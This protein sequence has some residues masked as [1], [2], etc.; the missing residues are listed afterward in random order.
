MQYVGS[1]SCGIWD[2]VPRQEF[3]PGPPALAA[4]SLGHWITREVLGKV[5]KER[6]IFN[7][8]NSRAWKSRRKQEARE[9]LMGQKWGGG[10][11]G[12]DQRSLAEV[13]PSGP[14]GPCSG[15]FWFS[16]ETQD[17]HLRSRGGEWCLVKGIQGWSLGL[18]LSFWPWESPFAQK[19]NGPGVQPLLQ[20]GCPLPREG[21]WYLP[22]STRNP[23]QYSVMAFMGKS[24]KRGCMCTCSWFA[25]LYAWN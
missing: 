12:R 18:V 4:Q 1:Y 24:K 14:E 10:K 22:Y 7:S 21:R 13:V 6:W 9:V 11:H 20:L 17:R 25:L 16:P 5:F 23:T 2:L 3:K 15:Q 19:G 8:V